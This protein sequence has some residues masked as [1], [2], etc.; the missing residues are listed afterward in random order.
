MFLAWHY[1]EFS[2]TIHNTAGASVLKVDGVQQWS[3]SSV[4][5]RNTA[6]NYANAVYYYEPGYGTYNIDNLVVM[7][8]TGSTFNALP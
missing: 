2:C 4:N 5:T 3:L 7:D 6:N 1:I 8:A